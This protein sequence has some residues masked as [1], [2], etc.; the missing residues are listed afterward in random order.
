MAGA[1]MACGL[2]TGALAVL[3]FG[4]AYAFPE[5]L[6]QNTALAVSGMISIVF[7]V[8]FFPHAYKVQ[9]EMREERK[10]D[11]EREQ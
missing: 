1:L 9:Q 3:L 11:P 2:I 7:F 8:R 10:E 6:F 4:V 5:G